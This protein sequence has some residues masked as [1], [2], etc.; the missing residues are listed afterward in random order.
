MKKSESINGNDNR[1]VF[2][3]Y[4]RVVAPAMPK[5]LSMPNAAVSLL[6]TT[7]AKRYFIA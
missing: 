5:S 7:V 6:S 3:D 4:V 1:V 2:V